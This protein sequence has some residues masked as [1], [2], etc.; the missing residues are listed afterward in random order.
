MLGRISINRYSL[1]YKAS[2]NTVL[3]FVLRSFPKWI[4]MYKIHKNLILFKIA[5]LIDNSL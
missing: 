3:P 1:R 2:E 4:G 5:E